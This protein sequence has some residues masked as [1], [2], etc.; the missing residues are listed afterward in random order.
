MLRSL[1]LFCAL[2]L[3]LPALADGFTHLAG[4]V[5]RGFAVGAEARLLGDGAAPGES[6]GAIE[7]RRQLSPASVS[8]AYLAAAALSEWGPQHRFT[9]RL[10]TPGRVDR[11][12]VLDGDLILEGSGDPGLV[13]EDLWKLVQGLRQRGVTAIRGDVLVSQ[14]R[15][16]PVA[17]VTTDRC[18]ARRR[19][20]NAYSAQLSAA[21]VNHG[22]WCLSIRP[23]AVGEPARALSCDTAEPL[24]PLDNAID[25][26]AAGSGTEFSVERAGE[27]GSEQLILRGRIAADAAPRNVH[28]ASADPAWQTAQTLG[29]L[30]IQ[31]GITVEGA[32]R[33]T[34][35]P[36]PVEVATL[37]AVD[38]RSLQ[39]LLLG[40]MHYSN[41]YMADVLTLG[42]A[43]GSQDL[44]AAG[45]ALAGFAEALPN[46]GPLTL[47]SGSGLTTTNR[48]T[49]AGVNV[50]LEH[51]YRQ[52]ALFPAFVAG[53]QSP[54]T[55]VMRFIRRGGDTFQ[56]HV[57]LKTGTLNQPFAVRAAA[58]YFRTASGR[59][60]VFS[61]LVNGN[62]TTP[63]L[64]W[65]EVLDPLA[66]DLE[67]MIQSR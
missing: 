14:W 19:A 3:P 23:G 60:G 2:L 41:N 66:R 44:P 58:G 45:A 47:D 36:P 62:G 38:G 33:V 56:H 34:R 32:P 29:A 16:G 24:L 49:A 5:E 63:Y 10:V 46:H 13:A 61:V 53:L 30:L 64:S 8:K 67:A 27:A 54:A 18:Q 40:V 17:C 22:S 39:E 7:P 35:E 65:P 50:L 51:M 1:V 59:W 28:R 21:G 48:T 25:T 26:V 12:G 11:E 37:S 20:A 9:T 55:G 31:A 4:L 42:L 15:F 6:L 43:E 52:P 57:M